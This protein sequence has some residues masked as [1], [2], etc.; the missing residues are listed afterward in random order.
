MFAADALVAQLA[1]STHDMKLLCAKALEV[2][3]TVQPGIVAGRINDIT[4]R[5]V[6]AFD[7]RLVTL[8]NENDI[9]SR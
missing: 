3:A 2:V 1:W 8:H 4:P 6:L 5:Y 9:T 7:H